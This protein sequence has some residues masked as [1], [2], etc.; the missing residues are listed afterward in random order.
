MRIKTVQIAKP[1]AQATAV[2]YTIADTLPGL[3]ALLTVQNDIKQAK[4]L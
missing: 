2:I 4:M 3:D 1:A